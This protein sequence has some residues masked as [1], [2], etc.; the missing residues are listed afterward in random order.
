MGIPC[1]IPGK[2]EEFHFSLP[3]GWRA[4]FLFCFFFF[5]FIKRV[6][7]GLI[8]SRDHIHTYCCG[9]SWSQSLP[10]PLY[11]FATSTKYH[12]ITGGCVMYYIMRNSYPVLKKEAVGCCETLQTVYY[13][14]FVYSL[15]PRE[16]TCKNSLDQIWCVQGTLYSLQNEGNAAKLIRGSFFQMLWW[17]N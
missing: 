12:D 8:L 4:H 1:W 10:F 14:L 3:T 7:M 15:V 5:H 11:A 16:W 6:A 17:W 9:F 13:D 2:V